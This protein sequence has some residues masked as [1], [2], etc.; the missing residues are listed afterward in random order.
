M[1]TT[2][3]GSRYS[4]YNG[5]NKLATLAYLNYP[6]GVAVNINGDIY[7]ADSE[8]HRIRLVTIA[9]GIITTIAGTGV[10]GYYGDGGL[11]I[12]ARLNYPDGIA[13]ATNGNFYITDR[14]NNRIRLVTVSSGLH[15]HFINAKITLFQ[16]IYT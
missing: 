6:R 15:I 3:A 12:V 9:T 1:I 13:V 14:A 8:N 7:I 5:D 4:S 10:Y 2:I 16:Y 11:A